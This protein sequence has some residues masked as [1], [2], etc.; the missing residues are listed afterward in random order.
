[1]K[2]ILD[3]VLGH[4]AHR[5]CVTVL[6]HGNSEQSRT[7]GDVA[8]AAGR[9]AGALAARGVRKGDLV[10]LVGTHHVDFYATWLG[11]IWL[12]A[13]P[14]VLAE[15]SVRI[16]KGLYWSRLREQL[17]R[18][19]ARLLAVDPRVELVGA[20]LPH[21]TYEELA[22]AQLA[23]P[24]RAQA[25]ESDLLLLQHSSGT[26]GLHKGVMLSH[27]AVMRHAEAYL[28]LLGL[29]PNDVVATWLPLYHD[30]GLIACFVSPLIA[31]V[32]VVWLSPF[33]WVAAPGLLHK[34][35]ARHR[36]TLAWLPNFA[37]AFLSQRVR[38]RADLSSLR[39]VIN[40]SEPVTADAFDAFAARFREDGLKPEALHTCYAMAE[41]VFAVSATTAAD[42]PRR[43]KIDARVWRDEHRAV[44][45]DDGAVHI[46]NG[47]PVPG[48][49]VRVAGPDGE[50]LPAMHAGR[51]LIRSAFLLSGYFRRDDLN[52]RLFDADGF[53]DTGDLGWL[54][55]AGH[56][57]VTGRAKDLVIVGGRNIYPQDVE[58]I[59]NETAG[60][61]PGRA[62]C[63]GIWLPKLATEG[64]VVLAESDLPESEWPEVV[65]RLRAA[66]PARLDLDL[67]DARVV[68]PGSLRK[69]TSGKLARGGNREWYLEG[70]FG[71]PAA[72]VRA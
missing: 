26:T 24:P 65:R 61:H 6:A 3:L 18:I 54:D 13:V 57:Y 55:E 39:A 11:T 33:E 4:P 53:Y 20:E 45:A 9:A 71:A 41:N 70:R 17:Q 67:V 19:D 43:L 36:A 31:G 10:V 23:P 47:P 1:M 60:V 56:V 52:A 44:A 22:S 15:P 42:P 27:G 59:A 38:D 28:P 8:A 40:C 12:G 25:A 48:C 35:I 29:G 72:A 58:L 34:A 46:S 32:P 5:T 68:Q 49:E 14:T 21:A 30:M 63:F 64:L 69:S 37:F 66:V 2:T 62:V 51:L 16:D 50:S 7:F